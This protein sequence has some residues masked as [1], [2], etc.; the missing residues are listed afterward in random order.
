MIRRFFAIL[1]GII[2]ELSDQNAYDRHL[3]AHGV[4]HSPVEWRKF[5]DELWAA[6]AR[7]GRC[8]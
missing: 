4:A 6:Q 8:C 1:K 7:R 3:K 5:Q 2:F